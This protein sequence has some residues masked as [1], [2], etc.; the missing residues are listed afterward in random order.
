MLC[1]PAQMACAK[2]TQAG[3]ISSHT[4][5]PCRG[6]RPVREGT[7][8]RSLGMIE[9]SA[10][11]EVGME[12]WLQVDLVVLLSLSNPFMRTMEPPFYRLK[13]G[14]P[15]VTGSLLGIS[16]VELAWG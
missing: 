5:G 14:R 9:A 3:C 8:P 4:K 15:R 13:V 12:L 2:A 1:V 6:Y 11:I 16:T 7:D 10:N